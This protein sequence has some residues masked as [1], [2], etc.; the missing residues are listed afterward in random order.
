MCVR[1]EMEKSGRRDAE[2]VSRGRRAGQSGAVA[3]VPGR[4]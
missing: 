1:V 4:T 2:E 3:A